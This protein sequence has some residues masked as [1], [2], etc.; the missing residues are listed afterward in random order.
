VADEAMKQFA[1]NELNT[2]LPLVKNA[3][4]SEVTFYFHPTNDARCRDHGPAFVVN[5]QTG[6]KAVVDWGYNAWGGKYLRL[7]WTMLYLP[8]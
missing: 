1:L 4:L 2:Y 7:T 6:E 5:K 3:N 8:V